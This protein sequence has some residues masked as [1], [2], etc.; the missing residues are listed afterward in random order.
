LLK[1]SIYMDHQDR[2]PSNGSSVRSRRSRAKLEPRT[3]RRRSSSARRSR[4]SRMPRTTWPR[5]SWCRSRRECRPGPH[6][7]VGARTR[8]P[9]AGG[10][11]FLSGLF[12]AGSPVLSRITLPAAADARHAAAHGSGMGGM[13]PRG[14]GGFLAGAAQTAMGLPAACSSAT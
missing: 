12:G 4:G 1:G 9:P 6:S 2:Q 8:Q 7:A 11:G 10:G 13:A 5:P 3:H 14:G